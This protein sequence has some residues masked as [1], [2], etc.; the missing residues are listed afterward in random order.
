MAR[1]KVNRVTV[2]LDTRNMVNPQTIVEQA[3]GS[4]IFG[5]SAALYGKI[6]IKRDGF[7][8]PR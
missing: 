2:A 6:T 5:P 1:V 7:R 3:E 4:V 8:S